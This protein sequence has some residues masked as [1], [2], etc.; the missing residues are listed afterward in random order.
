MDNH[1]IDAIDNSRLSVAVTIEVMRMKHRGVVGWG[2]GEAATC[3]GLW[4]REWS[5]M[6][7][8]TTHFMWRL[9]VAHPYLLL[10]PVPIRSL[11]PIDLSKELQGG[12]GNSLFSWFFCHAIA[13]RFRVARQVLG[14]SYSC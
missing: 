13:R 2:H 10:G 14:L 8:N 11:G 4:R 12:L 1:T 5:Q 7:I 9:A 3:C 6:V